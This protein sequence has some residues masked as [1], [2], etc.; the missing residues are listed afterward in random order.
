MFGQQHTFSF[1]ADLTEFQMCSKSS[2]LHY[3]N[4]A[5]VPSEF[6]HE[7]CPTKLLG[8]HFMSDF[9]SE[10]AML[11]FFLLPALCGSEPLSSPLPRLCANYYLAV[12]HYLKFTRILRG[13]G[14]GN[15]SALSGC[16]H[17][18]GEEVAGGDFW[19]SHQ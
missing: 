13:H 2:S 8:A 12:E 4:N 7:N 9:S 11:S 18:L 15:F 1:H 17:C 19:L 6:Q 16:S 14:R 10:L 5:N 3:L